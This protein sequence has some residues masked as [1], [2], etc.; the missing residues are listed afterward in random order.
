MAQMDK[1]NHLAMI[2]NSKYIEIGK[3][4]TSKD[5]KIT[6]DEAMDLAKKNYQH[7][8]MLLKIF[9][10]GQNMKEKKR[11]RESYMNHEKSSHKDD[12]FKDHKKGLKIQ[13]VINGSGV[14]PA[15]GGE[16]YSVVPT[17]L[18]IPKK[19]RNQYNQLKK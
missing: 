15:R 10:M 11:F 14:F 16:L 8:S 13:P 12:I 1:S 4:H 5:P 18:Q 9:N 17:Q 7:T 2:E 3:D 19:E 6:L